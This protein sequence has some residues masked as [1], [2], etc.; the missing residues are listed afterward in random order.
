MVQSVCIYICYR[1]QPKE[2]NGERKCLLSFFFV[3]GYFVEMFVYYRHPGHGTSKKSV[4]Q[5]FFTKFLT[6]REMENL[7]YKLLNIS[8]PCISRR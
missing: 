1:S 2:I 5:N 3:S 6:W 7:N 4:L 8:K